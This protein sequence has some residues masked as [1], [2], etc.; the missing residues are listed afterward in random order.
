MRIV[1]D[2]IITNQRGRLPRPALLL[3]LLEAKNTGNNI[4]RATLLA[5]INSER[6]LD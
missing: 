2:G 1:S 5:E 3:Y 6:L 4:N